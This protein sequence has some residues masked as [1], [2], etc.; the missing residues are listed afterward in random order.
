LYWYTGEA[1]SARLSGTD[2]FPTSLPRH[3]ND[4]F[5]VCGPGGRLTVRFPHDHDSREPLISIVNLVSYNKSA[6]GE[7]FASMVTVAMV[8]PIVDHELNLRP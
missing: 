2:A 4:K 6:T 5:I 8:D 1:P 3:R 7:D